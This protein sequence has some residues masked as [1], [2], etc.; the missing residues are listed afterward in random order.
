MAM[1]RARKAVRLAQANFR[2]GSAGNLP[3]PSAL[4]LSRPFDVPKADPAFISRGR[5]VSH[6]AHKRAHPTTPHH[7]DQAPR[8][9]EG[10]CGRPA[11]RDVSQAPAALG[12]W[13]TA[14]RGGLASR[15]GSGDDCETN[16]G[17]NQEARLGAS[18]PTR[19]EP[20]AV[21]VADAG[22]RPAPRGLAP[23]PRCSS[24]R[25]SQHHSLLLLRPKCQYMPC[26]G[27]LRWRVLS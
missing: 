15:E 13:P 26:S 14:E 16:L 18:L 7:P 19:P 4:F 10:W 27:G 3:P 5:V 22:G 6:N 23:P 12:A 11:A 9:C 20:F 24:L 25:L 1:S 17:R 2:P 8:V 21:A